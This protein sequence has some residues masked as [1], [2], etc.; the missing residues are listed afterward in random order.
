MRCKKCGAYAVMAQSGDSL[1]CI[2]KSQPRIAKLRLDTGAY[3]GEGIGFLTP[4]ESS[5]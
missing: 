4:M 5:T 1:N 3:M 2:V